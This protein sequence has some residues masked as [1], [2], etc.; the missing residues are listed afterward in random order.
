MTELKIADPFLR[1]ILYALGVMAV[2]VF[3]FYTFG[4]LKGLLVFGLNVLSPFLIGLI[5]AYILAPVVIRLQHQLR[6]GRV[7]GTLMVYLII[8]LV[9]SLILLFLIPT[10]VSQL[11]KLSDA[12]REGVPALL[13]W[14]SENKYLQMDSNFIKSIQEALAKIKID[15][16]Q[17]ASS[18]L[19]AFQRIASGGFS[20]AWSILRETF[21]S[22]RAVIAFVGFLVFIGIINF[23]LILD[24]ERIGPFIRK[25][26]PSKH[27]ERVFHILE[28]MDFAVGGFLRGQITVAAIVGISF[29]AGLFG[30]G[31]MGF[32]ALRNFAILIGTL[33]GVSGF[34]PYLGA[35]IGVT[36]AILIV[37]LSGGVTWTTRIIAL[38]AVLSLFS[39][40]Q[41]IEGFV[42]QPKIVGRGAGLHPLI[43]LL[44]LVV[45]AQF[46]LGGMVVAVP[47]TAMIRVVV[48]EFYWLPIIERE[49]KDADERK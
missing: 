44:A 47:L 19:P 46:G 8:F 15:H 37:I 7:L 25:M 12:L 20:A 1:R 45:G 17:I 43:V 23:Y 10:I 40:I 30:L 3:G 5:V 4:V 26:V 22:L 48:R 34:I 29:A 32:P 28:K 31:F 38:I 6:L 14:L 41:A 33:A 11:I 27:R 35:I 24:W 36:P 2:I 49:A 21:S 13:K 16:E 18:I 39:L 42:L 9:I